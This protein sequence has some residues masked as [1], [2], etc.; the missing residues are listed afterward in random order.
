MANLNSLKNRINVVGN[1]KKITHAM[2]LV[3]ASKL[4]KSRQLFDS[5]Q[6]YQ[7]ILESTFNDIINN[8]DKN[9][10]NKLF[11][12]NKSENTLYIVITSDL[13][14]CGSYNSNVINLLKTK[15]IKNDKIIAIGSKGIAMINSSNFKENIINT[16]YGYGDELSYKIGTKISKIALELYNSKLI[17]KIK[18]IYT[19]FI[20]N[21]VQNPV[22]KQLFPLTYK[23]KNKLKALI[24]FEPDAGTV[25]RNSIPLYI[26]SMIYCLGT[27]S[28]ISELASRRN[29]MENATNNAEELIVDLNLQ[30]NRTRQGI[31]TQEITEIVS[32]ADA[33]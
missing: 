9:E 31:I 8:I 3:A 7:D 28:K 26:A 21:M 11:E 33:T 20:S 12:E 23:K 2:E 6:S 29:A 27:S 15:I 1:T 10:L 14:L 22:E 30:Y 18:I 25:L 19:E 16:F 32:G 24:E 17:N 4:R 13:G 5:I